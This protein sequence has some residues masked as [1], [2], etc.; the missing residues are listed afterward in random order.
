MF[1]QA[2]NNFV[3]S[4]EVSIQV[5]EEYNF[6]MYLQQATT[7]QDRQKMLE[8][9]LRVVFAQVT[10]IFLILLLN[11]YIFF[12]KAF[13]IDHSKDEMLKLELETA[14]EIVSMELTLV[15]FSEALGMSPKSDFAQRIFNLNDKNKSGFISFR[16]FVD[17]LV[18]FANGSEDDKMKLLF[19]MYDINDIGIISKDDFFDMIR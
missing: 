12:Y 1:Y 15:E 7:K 8:K 19:K 5:I 6:K 9:F 17:L 18:I 2:L 3:S 14:K 16:E 11:L 13:K 10:L 4:I